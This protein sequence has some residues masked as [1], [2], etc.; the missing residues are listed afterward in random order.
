MDANPRRRQL[1]PATSVNPASESQQMYERALEEARARLHFTDAPADRRANRIAAAE[2]IY[3]E[4]YARSK[5]A[6][7]DR[8][9]VD[10]AFAMVRDLFAE[11]KECSEQARRELAI[12]QYEREQARRTLV[13]AGRRP[14]DAVRPVVADVPGSNLCPNPA[15]AHTTADFMNALRM[16]R[17]WAG[18]PSYRVMEHQCGRRFAASTIC[19]ALNGTRLPSLDMVLTV[20]VACGGRDEHQNAFASAWRRLMLPQDD[21]DQTPGQSGERALYSVSEPA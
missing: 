2:R 20:I 4:A 7:M 10:H 5:A 3:A 19:T 13:D 1:R 16:F 6:G 9:S 18:K 8:D 11:A 15:D 17:I 14:D 12:A 21:A